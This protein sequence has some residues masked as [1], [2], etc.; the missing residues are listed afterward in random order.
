MKHIKSRFSLSL[1]VGIIILLNII[2][3]Y[4]FTRLDLTEGKIYSLSKASKKLVSELDD[5]VIVKAFFSQELPSQLKTVPRLVKDYLDEYRVYSNGNFQY[6]FVDPEDSEE[7]EK[8]AMEYKIPP[9]QVQVIDN[10]AI[11]VKKVHLGVVLLYEDKKEIIPVIQHQ[12]IATLEYELTSRIKKLTREKAPVIGLAT[13]YGLVDENKIGTAAKY[14]REQYEVKTINLENDSIKNDLSALIMMSPK[15]SLSEK[16]LQNIDNYL[17]NG[18]KIGLYL[19]RYEAQLQTQRAMPIE[20]NFYDFLAKYGIKINKDVVGDLQCGAITVASQQGFFT[21][22]HQIEFPYIPLLNDFD[23][24]NVMVKN[25]SAV[26]LFFASSIDT[27]GFADLKDIKI[28]VLARTSGKS[29]IETNPSYINAQKEV[30]SYTYDKSFLPV[31]MTMQGA[32]KSQFNSSITPKEARLFIL[33]DSDFIQDE[34][35][36]SEETLKFFLNS[37]DWL[38]SDKDLITIRSKELASRPLEEISDNTKKLVKTMNILLIPLLIALFGIF[39][40]RNRKKM[41]EMSL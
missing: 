16:A 9:I 2:S 38:A 18:G 36:L 41:Q 28:N 20:T 13:G 34:G 33:T 39:K 3:L 23:K 5:K 19:D 15:D 1:I 7:F 11:S 10:D 30:N 26:P 27:S 6:E 24:K 37:A 4:I 14:L 12:N 29:F 17:V 31:C 25:L 35:L 32:F 22:Q 21:F 40:W 8:K